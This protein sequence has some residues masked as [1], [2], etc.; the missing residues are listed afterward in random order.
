MVNLPCVQMI[1]LQIRKTPKL[2]SKLFHRDFHKCSSATKSDFSI[3]SLSQ[4]TIK[5]AECEQHPVR[6]GMPFLPKYCLI[7]ALLNSSGRGKAMHV[8]LKHKFD[9]FNK[10]LSLHQSIK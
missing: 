10:L 5:C 1:G 9:I 2:N 4:I 8:D 6:G 3:A 7:G